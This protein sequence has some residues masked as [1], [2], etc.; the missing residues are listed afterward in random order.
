MDFMQKMN[1]LLSTSIS[2]ED[3]TAL[4]LQMRAENRAILQAIMQAEHRQTRQQAIALWEF[5]ARLRVAAQDSSNRAAL[6]ATHLLPLRD[7]QEVT[8][9]FTGVKGAILKCYPLDDDGFDWAAHLHAIEA[10]LAADEA[11]LL[12]EIQ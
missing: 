7:R 6:F 8:Y 3:A 11:R 2:D 5:L 12:S 10:A 4:L 1:K 9:R